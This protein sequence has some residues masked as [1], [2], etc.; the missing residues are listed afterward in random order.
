MAKFLLTYRGGSMPET[1]EAQAQVMTAWTD[2]F[3]AIGPALADGGNPTSQGKT[4]N[5]DGSVSGDGRAAVSG[6]SVISANSL[7]AA[8][9]LA[10]GC[11]VLA[12]GASIDVSETFEVM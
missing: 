2:W 9:G 6:Y 3:K 10:K 11:P 12:G 5:P 7:D 1:P 8:I 4:I